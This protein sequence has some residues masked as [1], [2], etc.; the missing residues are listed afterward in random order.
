MATKYT[1]SISGDFPN[2]TVGLSKLE[3]EIRTSAIPYALDHVEAAGDVCDI[4]FK[5]ALTSGDETT[6]SGIVAAHDGQYLDEDAP[7]MSDGRPIVRAD[8]RPLSTQTWFTMTG[9]TASGIGDGTSMVWDMDGDDDWYEDPINPDYMKKKIQLVFNDEL[10]LKD[11]TIYFYNAPWG[12]Y[13]EFYITIPAG[14]Y[15]P[16]PFGAIPAAA[17]GLPGDDMY[18]YASSDVKYSNYVNKHRMYGSCP[19]GD[20]LN[21]EGASVDGVPVGWYLEGHIH[22]PA[23]AS[24]TGFRGFASIECY[25]ERSVVLPGDP[26]GPPTT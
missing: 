16:N 19:M 1:F 2:S 20:E 15:Y 10:Y 6:L 18:A 14:S 4:W 9:D 13:C 24:G 26:L 12:A 7:K 3:Y 8:T 22:A 11:G 5:H 23:T 25:R 17:L 21:A